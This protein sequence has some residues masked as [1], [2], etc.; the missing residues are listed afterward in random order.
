MAT[1]AKATS[2]PHKTGGPLDSPRFPNTL[3]TEDTQETDSFL[4]AGIFEWIKDPK[5][6]AFKI[7]EVIA[8]EAKE[9]EVDV[10][11]YMRYLKLLEDP[12]PLKAMMVI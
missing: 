3:T 4:T 8:K 6:T 5:A 11:D 9:A 10:K 1:D 7:G 12:M 2:R